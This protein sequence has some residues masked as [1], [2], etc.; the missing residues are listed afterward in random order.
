VINL[1]L[2]GRVPLPT[3]D[4]AVDYALDHDVVVVAA[5][6]NLGN[7]GYSYPASF[8]GVRSVAALNT[9]TGDPASFSQFN[10][11]VDLAAPGTGILGPVAPP[12]ADGQPGAYASYSGTSMATPHVA[13]AAALLRTLHPG[14][15]AS[16]VRGALYATATDVGAAGRDDQTGFGRVDALTALS[17]VPVADGDLDDDASRSTG[18]SWLMVRSRVAG[19]RFGGIRPRQSRKIPR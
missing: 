12:A 2:G 7:G 13:G 14:W 5:A 9:G 6:G 11:R 1:S 17:H 4:D 3:W 10:D 18:R 15:T 19:S 16:Q 8:I